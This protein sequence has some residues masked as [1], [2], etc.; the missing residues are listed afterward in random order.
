MV[1]A[2]LRQRWRGSEPGFLSTGA[3]APSLSY[4]ALY[5]FLHPPIHPRPAGYSSSCCCC[6]SCSAVDLQGSSGAGAASSSK[7]GVDGWEGSAV[8]TCYKLSSHLLLLHSSCCP[9]AYLA[10]LSALCTSCVPHR[11]C[12]ASYVALF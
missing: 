12:N 8:G 9:V 1:F 2:A 10:H 6:C 4:F 5:P 3:A 7:Q 11:R